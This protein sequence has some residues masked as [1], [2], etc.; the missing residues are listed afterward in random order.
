[1]P[2]ATEVWRPVVGFV[3]IYEVSDFGR[4]RSLPRVM[5]NRHGT[6]SP[7]KGR[8]LECKGRVAKYPM[9]SLANGRG[10]VTRAIHTIVLEAF[11]G[12]CPEGLQCRHLN[13]DKSDNRLS[14]LCWGTPLE[15]AS[16]R[17]VTGQSPV[18]EGNSRARLTTTQVLEFRRLRVAGRCMKEVAREYRL[19]YYLVVNSANGTTWRH[20]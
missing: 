19:P 4:V 8:I 15:N 6:T 17:K 13:S 2:L 10:H 20:L 12:P 3:G 18:G 9:V 5:R 11:V 16:D 7:V 14:N 1:M